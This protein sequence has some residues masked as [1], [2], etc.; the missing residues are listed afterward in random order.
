MN[1][2]SFGDMLGRLESWGRFLSAQERDT[3]AVQAA[4][5][6]V[7]VLESQQQ[8]A[9]QA[10]QV[11]LAQLSDRQKLLDSQAAVRNAAYASIS[12]QEA[13]ASVSLQQLDLEAQ[14]ILG[15]ATPQPASR[16]SDTLTDLGTFKITAYSL[17]GH[18]A[19]GIPAGYGLVAVDPRLIPLGTRL[20]V[21]GYGNCLA[22]DTGGAI[23]GRHI[24]IWLPYEQAVRWGIR[25]RDVQEYR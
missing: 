23:L 16:S 24:D 2:S 7:A 11:L 21:E 3:A 15:G 10:Q 14:A 25:Y 9:Q 19:S 12:V 6:A 20:W 1:A 13:Q 5:S 22:A 18:T 17:T 4:V 8:A